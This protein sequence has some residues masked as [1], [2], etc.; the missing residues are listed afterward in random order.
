MKFPENGF[1]VGKYYNFIPRDI[2]E[3]YRLLIERG[4]KV[5]PI[6]GEGTTQFFTFFD[7]DGNPLG[8][9]HIYIDTTESFTTRRILHS[10]LF[11][12]YS[13]IL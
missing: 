6:S 10:F 13:L 9:C 2:N 8:V 3:T 1:G 12:S 11:F 7:P 4:V 5:N